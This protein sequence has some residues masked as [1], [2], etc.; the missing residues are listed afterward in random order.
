M[1]EKKEFGS[2]SDKNV[3]MPTLF[4]PIVLTAG[5]RIKINREI[6]EKRPRTRLRILPTD[7][8]YH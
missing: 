7:R 1:K 6:P 5:G 2:S 4:C 3:D 8:Q